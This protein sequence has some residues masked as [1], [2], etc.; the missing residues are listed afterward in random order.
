M[1]DDALS[2]LDIDG[3][4]ALAVD[5]LIDRLATRRAT[6]R[7]IHPALPPDDPDAI[8]HADDMLWHVRPARGRSALEFALYHPGLCW[9][10]IL[11]SRAQI[12]DLQDAIAWAIRD[13]PDILNRSTSTP[14]A[15]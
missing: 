2:T 5:K 11:M 12:E 3:L 9:T 1:P 8:H 7:P 15:A 10:S 13:M 14:A 6:L 4:D